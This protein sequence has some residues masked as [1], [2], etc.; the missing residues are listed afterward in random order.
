M[1]LGIWLFFAQVILLVFLAVYRYDSGPSPT[2]ADYIWEIYKEVP[3]T[4]PM[5]IVFSVGGLVFAQIIGLFARSGPTLGELPA[6]L[7]KH[8]VRVAFN[9][10]TVVVLA[11]ALLIGSW[12]LLSFIIGVMLTRLAEP[13]FNWVA[14]LV[15]SPSKRE[16]R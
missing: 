1:A 7:R 4:L 15:E 6:W 11:A 13:W 12:L 2:A 5:A 9:L 14:D 10:S 16:G 3:R 8:P